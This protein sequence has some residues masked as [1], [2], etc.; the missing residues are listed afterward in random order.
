MGF[1]L[2]HPQLKVLLVLSHRDFFAVTPLK[3]SPSPLP[4]RTLLVL[5]TINSKSPFS[6]TSGA[7]GWSWFLLSPKVLLR[8]HVLFKTRSPGT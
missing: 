4:L 1:S 3:E 5:I 8:V 2:Q 7:Q 6:R